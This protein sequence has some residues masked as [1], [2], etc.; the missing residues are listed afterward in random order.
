MIF[1]VHMQIKDQDEE[2]WIAE[3]DRKQPPWVIISNRYKSEE[4]GIG[5]FGKTHCKK[6]AVYIFSHYQEVKTFGPWGSDPDK[7]YAIKVLKRA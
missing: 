6:L 7:T 3:L 2:K 5:E 4:A 1:M